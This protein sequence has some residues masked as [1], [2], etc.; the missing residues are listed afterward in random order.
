MC[1]LLDDCF[2]YRH[3][4]QQE[5]AQDFHT[6]TVSFCAAHSQPLVSLLAFPP[7][8]AAPVIAFDN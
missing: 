6:F 3:K 1:K 7:L 4:N 8:P 5:I 2:A